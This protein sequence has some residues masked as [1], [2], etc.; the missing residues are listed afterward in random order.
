MRQDD[1]GTPYF[2]FYD[3][4]SQFGFMW[5]GKAPVIEVCHGGMGEPVIDTIKLTG[6]VGVS[7]ASASRWMDWFKLICC[8]YVRLKEG[9]PA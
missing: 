4:E 6:R 7:N 9:S 2:A 3:P 1:D 5:D 8:N